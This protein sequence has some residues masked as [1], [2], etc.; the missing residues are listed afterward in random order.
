MDNF[1]LSN[2]V[3]IPVIGFGTYKSVAGEDKTVISQAIECGYRHFDTAAFYDNEE[4]VGQALKESGIPRNE[5]FLTS[6]VW[7]EDLGYASTKKSFENS[8]RL[9]GTDY[10]DLFLIHWPINDLETEDWQ[11]LD[12]ETWRALEELYR[13]GKVRAIGVSNFLPHHLL[14]LMENAEI[15]PM[16]DQLEFH[17]GYM[18]YAA[19]EFCQKHGIQ[20]EAWSPLGRMR[21]MEEPVLQRMAK[22][23]GKSVPQ[24]CLRF[25]LQLQVIPLPKSSSPERMKV[26]LD[27]FDF[28]ISEGDMYRL[29][30]LPQI[31]WS[32]EHPD[33]VRV[34]I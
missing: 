31:G 21:M 25:A 20:V 15:K 34:P 28:T 27:V 29:K 14:N 22:K 32:G 8:L 23:Y 16:V 24:I 17:P 4:I 12:R 33:R 5:F 19:V 6:K 13:A 2:G 3:E 1:K 9:L 10:I 7:K 11:Q 26:N 30:T 18:Q